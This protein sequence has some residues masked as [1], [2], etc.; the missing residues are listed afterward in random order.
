MLIVLATLALLGTIF[1][2]LFFG[3]YAFAATRLHKFASIR[4]PAANAAIVK[5]DSLSSI[6]KAGEDVRCGS[7]LF[8]I[9]SDRDVWTLYVR[10]GWFGRKHWTRLKHFKSYDKAVNYISEYVYLEQTEAS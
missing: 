1:G 3:Y 10:E 9:Q 4:L 2:F 5:G 7:L 8:R 6:G